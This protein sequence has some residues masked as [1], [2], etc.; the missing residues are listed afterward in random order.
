M[1]NIKEFINS[2]F[3]QSVDYL[4]DNSVVSSKKELAESLG[5]KSNNMSDIL[6]GRQN[7]GIDIVLKLCDLYS[8]SVKYQLQGEGEMF[9]DNTDEKEEIVNEVSVVN[10]SIFSHD[11]EY[12]DED[13]DVLVNTN[14]NKFYLYP[15]NRIEIE[16]LK[17]P[18]PAYAS[19]L[20]CYQDE[21]S[22]INGF[23]FIRF[24]ADHI[25]KG[26]YLAFVTEG[27]SMNG[28]KLDDTPGGSEILARE[29][30]RQFWDN[31]HTTKYGLVF[32]TKTGIMHK[33]I[34]GYN[35]ETG[36]FTLLSRNKNHKPFEY[37]ANDVYQIFNVIKRSF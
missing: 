6:A 22:T 10:T 25:A 14:G 8:I 29:I 20:E 34:G 3:R 31:L 23:D 26:N 19:Y 15:N 11:N 30:G 27:E 2:N 9:A 1:K 33:D 4:I 17:V 7:V 24:K 12:L 37:P 16:V 21:M 35:S 36:M 32:V 13:V 5:I 18:F 28:G